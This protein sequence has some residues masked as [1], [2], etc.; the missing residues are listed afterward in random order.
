MA[1]TEPPLSVLVATRNRAI[2]LQRLLDSLERT[3]ATAG[4]AA[5]I[6]VADNG[7]SG[8]TPA[9]LAQWS[10]SAPTHRT[11][12]VDEPGKSR[13]LNHALRRA[14]APLLAFVD[15]D[16][17]VDATW[18]EGILAFCERHRE[19]DAA[20]GRVLPPRDVT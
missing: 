20:I 2:S 8:E 12:R 15:D 10:T 11:L 4:R 14:S 19:Y 18:M 7:S 6:V 3:Q 13:A 17:A 1:H 9:V 16:E 5:E